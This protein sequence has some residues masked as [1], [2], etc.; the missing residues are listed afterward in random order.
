MTKFKIPQFTNPALFE[1]AMT[2]RSYAHEQN[3]SGSDN[4]RLEFLGDCVL[5]FVSGDFPDKAEGELTVL[6]AAMVNEAQVAAFAQAIEL[7]QYLKLGKGAERD[8]ARD[9]PSVLSSTF[10]ALIGAYYLD[11]DGD[12]ESI[13][14]YLE[15]MFEAVIPTLAN[16]ASQVNYKSQ[17]QNWAQVNH[18]QMPEY[19][20][21][22]MSGPDH[23]KTFTVEVWVADR[24]LG[25]AEGRSKQVAQKLAAMQAL[26]A[27]EAL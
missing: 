4:E 13:R 10:E 8:R 22:D 2:H 25:R 18:Q 3:E 20:V 21:L 24:P 11:C 15:P 19:R 5:S 12:I 27:L 14:I 23:A 1:Q 26:K 9:R 6:R 17:L 16:T 7:G